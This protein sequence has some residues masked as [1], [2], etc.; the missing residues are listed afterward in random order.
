MTLNHWT[1]PRT[2]VAM[3]FCPA[4]EVEAAWWMGSP[5]WQQAAGGGGMVVNRSTFPC[6]VELYGLVTQVECGPGYVHHGL[7]LSKQ[8]QANDAGVLNIG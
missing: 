2:F 5:H 1:V 3:T 4:T 8:I 6:G 7:P